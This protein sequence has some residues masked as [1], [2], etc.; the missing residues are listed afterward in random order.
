MNT[1]IELS[2]KTSFV[3]TFPPKVICEIQVTFVGE[4]PNVNKKSESKEYAGGRKSYQF[5]LVNQG[6]KMSVNF[7]FLF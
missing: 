7:V 4:G 5:K 1:H 2:F 3:L 6:N